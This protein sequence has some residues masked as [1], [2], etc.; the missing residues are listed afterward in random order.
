VDIDATNAWLDLT[1]HGFIKS[2]D[3][4]CDASPRTSDE[5]RGISI[6]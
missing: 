6:N 5:K 1:L 3:E 2:I 4:C